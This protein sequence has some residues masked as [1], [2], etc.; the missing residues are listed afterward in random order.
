MTAVCAF[1]FRLKSNPW[2]QA[3]LSILKP[4]IIGLIASAA[5][6]LMNGHNFIDYKSWIIFG[7][8]LVASLKKV[9][10]ILLIMLSGV[11][12]LFLYPA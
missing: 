8:V 11:A 7:V 5:L 4:A 12:G 9:D 10:P 2:M 3:S 1:F 6:M